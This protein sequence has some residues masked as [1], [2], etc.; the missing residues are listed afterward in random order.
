MHIL[1]MV[2]VSRFKW[3]HSYLF[4]RSFVRV[5]MYMNADIFESDGN[6]P[7]TDFFV[8]VFIFPFFPLSVRPEFYFVFG[9]V[10]HFDKQT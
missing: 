5:A 3:A 6:G 8:V 2:Q 9:S 7:V 10:S 4:V 1:K